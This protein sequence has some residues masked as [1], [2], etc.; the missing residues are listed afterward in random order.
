MLLYSGALPASGE[1]RCLKSIQ[2]L[3]FE[4]VTGFQAV[5]FD[6]F[7]VMPNFVLEGLKLR[8][9]Y[10]GSNGLVS[11]LLPF[12]NIVDAFS[13]SNAENGSYKLEQ[14]S[15]ELVKVSGTVVLS[16][17]TLMLDDHHFLQISFSAS[18]DTEKYK[19]AKVYGVEG[20]NLTDVAYKVNP[21]YIPQG[22]R[23]VSFEKGSNFA[24]GF[25]VDDKTLEQVVLSSQSRSMTM[26]LSELIG[27]GEAISDT[28]YTYSFGNVRYTFKNS[29]NSSCLLE[30]MEGER[31]IRSYVKPGQYP[32]VVIPCKSEV[33][34]SREQQPEIQSFQIST[35]EGEGQVLYGLERIRL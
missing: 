35:S 31:F 20:I 21:L 27:Y 7:D 4:I 9:Q 26:G 3:R 25:R 33:W 13:L 5:N 18:S 19:S 24:F 32:I 16:P 17:A 15:E 29:D 11:E 1:I 8:V 28:A 23:T 30:P 6:P 10:V 22:V 12:V 14:I 2:A 34:S